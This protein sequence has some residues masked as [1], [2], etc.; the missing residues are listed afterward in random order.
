[1][2]VSKAQFEKWVAEALDRVPEKFRERIYNLAFFVEDQPT[3]VQ[4]KK[5]RLGEKKRGSTS[6]AL[7]RLSSV[8]ASQYRARFSGP[9]HYLQKTNGNSLSDGRG[10]KKSGFQNRPA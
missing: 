2:H 8:Q 3:S 4:L 6:R 5:A 1:M 9:D 10:T 7:R